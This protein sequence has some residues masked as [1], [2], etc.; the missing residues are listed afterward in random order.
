MAVEQAEMGPFLGD[1]YAA[2][3]IT[4]HFSGRAFLADTRIPAENW[5]SGMM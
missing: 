4:P 1:F 3:R 5:F 2:A